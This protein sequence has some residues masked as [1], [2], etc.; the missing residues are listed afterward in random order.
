MEQLRLHGIR[1][2][3]RGCRC[4]ECRAAHA[5]YELRRITNRALGVD[6]YSSPDFARAVLSRVT[7][8]Q[9]VIATGL[10]RS[11]LR[12]IREGKVKRILVETERKILRAA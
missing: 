3:W 6:A 12:Q 4:T 10:S 2:W 7:L 1:S 11:G 8:K 9:I 5:S